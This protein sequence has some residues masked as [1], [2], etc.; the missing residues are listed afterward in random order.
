MDLEFVDDSAIAVAKRLSDD[1][2][3]LQLSKAC[4]SDGQ[5]TN[6]GIVDVCS[7]P[8]GRKYYIMVLEIFQNL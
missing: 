1:D 3:N 2:W 7:A 8:S 4:I 5:L 6:F